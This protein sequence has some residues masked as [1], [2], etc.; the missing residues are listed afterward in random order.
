MANI[1]ESVYFA[2]DD[3]SPVSV[4]QSSFDPGEAK[5]KHY[6]VEE[7]WKFLLGEVGKYDKNMMEKW[8]KDLDALLVFAALFSAT[9]TAFTI[10]SYQW[11]SGD[12]ED[13]TVTLLTQIS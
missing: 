1:S 10:E 13:S 6:T 9:V 7:S 11:L 2:V 8:E 3:A 12:P 5:G 4:G